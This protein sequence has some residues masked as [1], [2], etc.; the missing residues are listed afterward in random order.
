M[1]ESQGLAVSSRPSGLI[2][3]EREI[4]EAGDLLRAGRLVTLT[5]PG[6]IGKTRLALAVAAAHDAGGSAWTLVDL[7]PLTD[8]SLVPSAIAAALGLRATAEHLPLDLVVQRLGSRPSLLLLDNLEHLPSAAVSVRELLGRCADLRI[9]AT[10]RVPLRLSMEQMFEVPPLGVPSPRR[11]DRVVETAPSVELFLLRADAVGRRIDP[12]GQ[13][14]A[15][16]EEICRRLEGMPLAIELA[17]ART[18]HIPLEALLAGLDHRLRLLTG[19]P[20]D[21]PHRHQALRDTIAWSFE[22]LEPVEAGVFVRLGA[23]AGAFSLGAAFEVAGHGVLTTEADVLDVLSTLVDHSLV[24]PA[25]SGEGEPRFV[26]LE[27]V[28]AFALEALEARDDDTTFVR[29]L[30]YYRD[31]AEKADAQ[32]EGPDQV[33]WTRVLVGEVENLRHAIRFA[34]LHGHRDE[35]IRLASALGTFWRLHGDLREGDERFREALSDAQDAD[36]RSVAK[37]QRRAARIADLLGDR[38]RARTLY[39]SAR[40]AAESDD[41]PAGLAEALAGLGMVT[42]ASGD[43]ETAQVL[44]DEALSIAEASGSPALIGPALM[45]KATLLSFRG[46]LGPSAQLL[47]QTIRIARRSGNRRLAAVALVNLADLHVAEGRHDEAVP[48]LA[49]G[50]EHLKAIEDIAYRGWATLLL[51]LALRRVGDLEASRSVIDRGVGLVRDAGAAED[52]V[53]ALEVVAEWLGEAS[54][55]QEA[56]RAWGAADRARD[57]RNLPLPPTDHAWVDPG[58]ARDRGALRSST[59]AL[60]WGEGRAR[61]LDDALDEAVVA[62]RAVP[63]GGRESGKTRHRPTLSA[64]ELEVLDLVVAGRSDGEIATVLFISPKTASVHVA[65]IKAKLGASS[66]VEIATVALRDGLSQA[67]RR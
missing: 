14:A 34:R 51:G 10:S 8:D 63:L 46:E 29:H 45:A 60:A 62:L 27:T 36:R 39:R 5:G 42:V 23:F 67:G 33:H 55:H 17:A 66:R 4:S 25:P 15:T 64:R 9:L 58:I 38:D 19:G 56:L 22:Q 61:D 41:D 31:L 59:A 7:A 52:L 20:S 48:L 35:Q 18:R 43:P 11:D 65:N 54:A 44:I 12:L 6:G 1:R 47:N 16:V 32:L 50:V 30:T 37:A 21:T 26:M 3:R 28:R 24:R 40:T 13:H 49:E 2:G 57:D 53:F